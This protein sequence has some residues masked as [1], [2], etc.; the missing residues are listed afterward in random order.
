M[1][2]RIHAEQGPQEAHQA[3]DDAGRKAAQERVRADE[4]QSAREDAERRGKEAQRAKEKAETAAAML[5][6][7]VAQSA[8]VQTAVEHAAKAEEAQREVDKVRKAAEERLLCGIPRHL[9][10]T[11]EQMQE[12]RARHGYGKHALNIA[13]IGESGVGK[14]ALLNALRGMCPKDE[15]AAAVGVNKT[16][17]VVEGYTDTRHP[18]IKWFDVPG[19]NT[20]TISGWKYFMDQSLYIFDVLVVVFSDRF[21]QTAETLLDNAQRCGIP[22]FIV[23]T[24]AD[25]L[26]RYIKGE[27]DRNKRIDDGKA[28]HILRT[29]TQ[30]AVNQSLAKLSL[31]T[32][33]FYLV[34]EDA[35]REWVVD[36][37]LSHTIDEPAIFEIL[38]TPQ[39]SKDPNQG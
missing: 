4:S 10:P 5:A 29:R 8:Q 39:P 16:T 17:A 15:G 34:S 22:A 13:I 24:K 27:F 3:S 9:R 2:A 23:R 35:M 11:P 26:V 18:H 7:T 28:R 33:G 32:Q 6:S 14:S 36:G 30:A 31:P 25:N 37:D 21:S 1:A 12:F 19:A 38:V 20:P